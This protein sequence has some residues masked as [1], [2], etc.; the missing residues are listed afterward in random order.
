MRSSRN[1]NLGMVELEKVEADE[2]VAELRSLIERH[3]DLTGSAVAA[4]ILDRWDEVAAAVREGDADR[5][6]T[7][8]ARRRRCAS[9]DQ[10][11]ASLS[12]TT[13]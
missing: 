13:I 4:D 7:R 6:Q 2:D 8:A 10:K 3:R 12:V 5:L 11:P 1:C 9:R